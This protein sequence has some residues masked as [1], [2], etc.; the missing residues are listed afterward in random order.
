VTDKE[1]LPNGNGENAA[2]DDPS[3]TRQDTGHGGWYG[4]F[5]HRRPTAGGVVAVVLVAVV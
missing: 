4:F 5:R 3:H 1:S 2:A